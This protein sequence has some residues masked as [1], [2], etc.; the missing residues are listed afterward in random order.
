MKV[1][2]PTTGL[3]RETV[4]VVTEKFANT[5][6][7]HSAYLTQ[8]GAE[9]AIREMFGCSDNQWR[10]NGFWWET[11]ATIERVGFAIGEGYRELYG[12][13]QH[14]TYAT[15]VRIEWRYLDE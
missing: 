11:S 8:G 13:K 3:T 9:K 2:N 12:P 6:K 5:K 10:R 15:G 14:G 7:I 4:F 1:T